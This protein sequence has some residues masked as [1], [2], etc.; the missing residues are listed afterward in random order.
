MLW[1]SNHYY[2]YYYYYRF[3]CR[4]KSAD[5]DVKGKLCRFR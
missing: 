1:W 5:S 3:G 4:G 2:Y